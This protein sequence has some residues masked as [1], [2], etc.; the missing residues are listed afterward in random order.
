MFHRSVSALRLGRLL[1]WLS[2]LVCCHA[3]AQDN[4]APAPKSLRVTHILGLQ[5]LK[6][7][8][9]G[10]LRIQAHT[11]RFQ[12]H[13]GTAAEIQVSSIQFVALGVQDKEVGGIPLAIG[14]AAT[15]FG[16]GRVIALFSHKKYEI[17]TVT[18][19]DSHDGF[20]GAIFQLT[21]GQGQVLMSELQAGGA[22]V[23][24]VEKPAER[25]NKKDSHDSK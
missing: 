1:A 8:T 19:R 9:N 15:P 17:V 18:Y 23:I 25:P 2:F 5:G 16:G 12:P 11:L 4:V 3:I 14:Q 21:K 24:E 6:E 10:L 13:D 7:N 20:H 22:Q